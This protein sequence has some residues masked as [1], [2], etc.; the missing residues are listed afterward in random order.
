MTRARR[1][2]ALTRDLA[3]AISAC[4]LT[5]LE[6]RPIDVERARSQHREYRRRLERLGCEVR[7]LPALEAQPD[8]LFVEDTAVVTDEL[9]V[10][11]RPGAPSRR[12]E[13]EA[14]A[15]ELARHRPLAR[16]E[17]PA[18]LD[19]GD[20]LRVD[21]RVWVGRSR[22]TSPDGVE[23]LA[24]HLEPLGYRV[25]AVPVSGCLHL[26][27]AVTRVG[28]RQLLANPEWVDPGRF[29]GLEI[30][31]VD[32]DEPFAANALLVGDTVLYPR[33]FP[34]TRARLEAA[35]VAVSVLD[36]SEIAKAEGGV[37][38]CSLLLAG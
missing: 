12:P 1:P 8:G 13:V 31:E 35:G 20:V 10:L 15:P 32:P 19:G 7:A 4:E 30:I 5:H 9:A 16:I 6:R 22:R 34:A 24:R 25:G 29:A 2:L 38:C 33:A 23:Q 27:S 11:C 37:T 18:T 28:R 21:R 17:A 26:K 36:V 14:I 3:G